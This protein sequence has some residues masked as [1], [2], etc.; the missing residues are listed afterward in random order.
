MLNN[1]KYLPRFSPQ[2]ILG[3]SRV[4][5]VDIQWNFNTADTLI[6]C[7]NSESIEGYKYA[8]ATSNNPIYAHV[9]SND[10]FCL[11]SVANFI[12]EGIVSLLLQSTK[13]QTTNEFIQ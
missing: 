1:V 13:R 9:L 12:F 4:C 3:N 7:K 10:T 6:L 11:K 2:S 8:I 5:E